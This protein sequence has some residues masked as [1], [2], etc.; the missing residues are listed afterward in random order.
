MTKNV[1][2]GIQTVRAT[3]LSPNENYKLRIYARKDL[4]NKGTEN[5][6]TYEELKK[7]SFDQRENFGAYKSTEKT[8]DT[9]GGRFDSIQLK[10][11]SGNQIQILVYN[12]YNLDKIK[13]VQMTVNWVDSKNVAHTESRTVSAGTTGLFTQ[14]GTTSTYTTTIP[15]ELTDE[16]AQYAVTVQ[17]LDESG[18]QIYKDTITYTP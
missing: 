13:M 12:G 9:W 2:D 11:T 16:D 17:F 14:K 5:G 10:T 8:M 18:G 6:L 7:W 4:E 3:G 15:I 1:A